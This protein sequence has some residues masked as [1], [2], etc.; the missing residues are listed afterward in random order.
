MRRIRIAIGST[1]TALA[2]LLLAAGAAFADPAAAPGGEA[3]CAASDELGAGWASVGDDELG[4][5]RGGAASKDVVQ[6]NDAKLN[7]T[8]SGNGVG[9]N[10]VTGTVSFE[11]SFHDNSG[12][13]SSMINSGNNVSMQN[14]MQVNIYLN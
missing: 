11:G 8:V 9:D 10:S 4:G 14:S 3:V 1:A 7:S 2:G 13:Q 6:I 12:I 5:Q